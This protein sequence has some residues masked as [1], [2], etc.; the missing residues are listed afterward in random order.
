M[1]KELPY[2]EL[3]NIPDFCAEG[4]G[5]PHHQIVFGN[6]RDLIRFDFPVPAFCGEK[7]IILPF[8]EQGIRAD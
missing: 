7:Q 1:K 3:L 5:K 6:L 8:M 2:R 4:S